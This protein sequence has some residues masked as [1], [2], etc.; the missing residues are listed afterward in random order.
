MAA[1]YDITI[2]QGAT[3]TFDLQV[4]DTD[5]TGFTVRMQ[6]RTS[7][8]ATSTVFSLTNASGITVSHQ[9]NHSHIVPLI[10]A[11]ATAAFTAP[12]AGVYDIEYESGGVVTRILEGSFYITPEVTR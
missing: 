5:L 12:L 10:S 6:G 2:E 8:A 3:F 7:H 4:N 9:G 11:T 1:R